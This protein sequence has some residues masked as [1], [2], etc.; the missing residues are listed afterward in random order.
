MLI[1][2]GVE[3]THKN[4]VAN[5]LT[6]KSQVTMKPN[7]KETL[8]DARYM[9]FLPLYHAMAQT[10]YGV[11]A[12]LLG[13]PT[14]IMPK[15]DFIKVLDNVQRFRITTLALVPP[16]VVMMAK[17]PDVKRGKWDLSSVRTAVAGAA[18]LGRPACEEF[19]ALWKGTEKEGQVNLSQG[20][21]MTEYACISIM[22]LA[23]GAYHW[24]GNVYADHG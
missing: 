23:T 11:T 24:Q 19:E 3:I 18:P 5:S 12:P 15:F 9:C 13:V 7:Y 21:G 8:A 17:H 16:I 2:I 1:P 4:Y 10:H 14:Y 22:N 6:Q 20:W